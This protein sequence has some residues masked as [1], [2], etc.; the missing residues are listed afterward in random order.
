MQR[1]ATRIFTVTLCHN[2][3]IDKCLNK[4]PIEQILIH[5]WN[6]ILCLYKNNIVDNWR[7]YYKSEF[8][9]LYAMLN[10]ESKLH[11]IYSMSPFFFNIVS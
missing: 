5:L 1:F 3:Y 7:R 11:I 9:R 4:W 2:K 6:E 10:V 8:K